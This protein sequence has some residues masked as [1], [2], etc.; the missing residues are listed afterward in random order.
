MTKTARK[1]LLQK[2]M[3]MLMTALVAVSLA[4]GVV[5]APAQPIASGSD[6]AASDKINGVGVKY[7]PVENGLVENE[8][9]LS[10]S[11]VGSSA[12]KGP[13]PAPGKNVDVIISLDGTP[14]MDYATER[15]MTVAQSLATADGQKNLSKLNSIRELALNGISKYIIEKR[16]DY[17]T[18]MNAFSATVKYGDIAAIERN[19]N[20]K[21]VILSQ[22]YLAPQ[23]ITENKVDVYESGIFNSAGVGYDG[24]GTV[25]A[26]VDTGTDYT[27]EVFDMEL[28]ANT[29]AINKDDVARVASVLTAT[30]LSAAEGEN[31]NED[32]LYISSKLPFAYDYA[33][34]D[35]NVYPNSSHGT[36][37]AGIIAGKSDTIT[38]V[39]PRAQIATFKVF[40]D[41]NTGAKT[42]W[43]LAGL[44]DAVTLGVDA[45]NMSLGSSC[46]FTRE[47]DEDNIN[48][49]YD[50]I[51]AAGICLVVAASNDASSAQGSTWGNTNLATN[52]DSGTVGSP[53][54]YTAA[55]SVASVSGVKTKYFMVDNSEVYF[56]ESRLMG[57]TDPND[58]V[59]GMLKGATEG[60]FEYI[61]IPG[62]GIDA[63]YTTDQGE[64]DVAGKIAV[65]KRGVSNFEAK[66][67]VAANHGAIGVIV[68][69]N[70]SGTIGMSVGT[71]EVIPSC[72]VT[73][74]YAERLVASGKGKI[75]LS[76][77]YLAGPFMSDF[78]SW[79]ALPNLVLAPDITAH[80]GDIYSS[81]AGG[82]QYD[83]LSGTSMACPNLAG[84]LILVREF[85]KE[86]NA[87][88]TAPQVRDE[89][90]SRM[91]STATIVRNEEGNPYSPRK[92]G[93]GIANI[94]D[95]INTKA[96]LT[97]D[98]SN[99]PKISLGDDPD[100]TGVYEFKFNLVN[101]SSNA[102]SYD[103]DQLVMT[104]SMSS[105]DITVA[106]KAYMFDDTVNTYSI[107]K[108]KGSSLINGNTVTVGGYGEV[109]VNAR[110]QLSA[111]D[112]QYIDGL[113]KNG[114]FVEGYVVL[115]SNNLD[116]IDLNIPFM[117]FY[118]NW[119]DAPMLD[120]SAYEV[121]E[122]AVDDSVKDEDKLKAD[123]YGTLPYSG[124][125]STYGADNMGYWGMGAY[126]FNTASGYKTPVTQEKFAALSNNSDGD[127]MLYMI[128]AGLL[129]CAKRV[130]MEIRNSATGELVWSGVDYN[131]RKSHGSGGTQTGGSVMI[132]LDIR[133]LDLPNNSKYTFSMTCYLDWKGDNS[134]VSDHEDQIDHVDEYT[135]GN[136][137]TF[138]FEFT[139]DDEK[140]EISSAALRKQKD[141]NGNYRYALE[142]NLYDNHY[143]Q[144][145]SIYT[146][147]GKE[148]VNGYE[149]LT[150][151]TSLV[152]GVIP[153]DGEFNT[154]TLCSH[155][156]SGYWDIIQKNGGKLYVMMYDYAKNSSAYEMVIT[157]DEQDVADPDNT[158]LIEPNSDLKIKKDR[159]AREDYTLKVNEQYDL[160]ALFTV[161]ANINAGTDRAPLYQEGYWTKD[162][163]WEVSDPTIADL[164]QLGVV[165]GLKEGETTVRVRTPNVKT[166]DKSDVDH[167]AEF[168]III[169]GEQAGG[170]RISGVDLSMTTLTL[171]RGETRTI[172]ATVKPYNY[173]GDVDIAWTV[174]SR[175]VDMVVSEDKMSVTI[176]ARNS[177]S[178]R[179]MASVNGSFINGSCDVYI[180]NEFVMYENIYL[181]SYNGKGGDFVNEKGEVEHNVVN[182]PDDL[183]I[184]Y[185]YPNAFYD[186]PDIRK[187]IIPEGVTEIMRFAFLGCENLEEVVLPSTLET[188]DYAVFA[189]CPKL[190]KINL[191]NVKIV[192]DS[193]FFNCRALEE[194]NLDKCTY[195]DKF[196]FFNCTSL[197]RMDLSRVGIIGGGAF[198]HCSALES[199]T[200]PSN[201]SMDFE[202]D[203]ERRIVGGAFAF[204]V[205]LKT[206]II[207]SKSVGEYAFLGC[208][209]LE[210]VIF[211]NDVE[212]INQYAFYNCE[213][214]K[215][216]TFHGSLYRIGDAAFYGC[217]ALQSITL[218][219]GL[220]VLGYQVFEGCDALTEINISSGALL[221]T[222]D[223]GSL[224]GLNIKAFNVENGN[225]Y[226]SSIDGVLYDRA[227]KRLIA[228]PGAKIGE[229]FAVPASVRTI[230]Q[231]AFAS[232]QNLYQI[233]LGKVEYIEKYAFFD[234]RFKT[235]L[236]GESMTLVVTFSSY[237][238]IKYIGEGAFMGA[239]LGNIPI[240]SNVTYIGGRAFYGA[241]MSSM[242]KSLTITMP[243]G[244]EYLG[245]RA[246]AGL[247]VK[248][249]DSDET[250]ILGLPITSVSFAGSHIKTVGEGVF[251]N[252]EKLTNIVGFGELE[253]LSDR[254]FVG[255]T[256]LNSVNI[257]KT[258]KKLGESVFEG[259]TALSNVNFA[260]DSA[261]TDISRNAFKDTGITS[262]TLPDSLTAIG[263]GAFENTR[264]AEINLKDVT[265]IGNR[266]FASTRLK[267]VASSKVKTVGNSAFADC[268]DLAS[269]DFANAKT[270]GNSAFKNCV[271]LTAVKL[272]SATDIGN[273]AFSGCKLMSAITL[274]NAKKIG[275]RAFADASA[276][277]AVGL[278]KLEQL[279][280]E[281]FSGTSVKTVAL[282]VSLY[283]VADNAFWGADK[284][285]SITVDKAN[286]KFIAE[287][288]VLYFLNGSGMYTLMCYPANKTDLKE[289]SV[290]RN[291]IRIGAYAFSANKT[292]EKLVFPAY[293]QIIGVSAMKGMDALTEITLNAVAAPTLESYA[294][295]VYPE[296]GGD[297][298]G[299]GS[300]DSDDDLGGKED[301]DE[302]INI[303]EG[304][305]TNFY[306]NFNF[307][308][309]DADKDHNLKIYIPA[310]SIGY[311][312]RIWNMYVGKNIEYTNRI[313]ATIG[314][315]ELVDQMIAE[316]EKPTHDA[317]NI[318]RLLS[319]YNMTSKT[320][321]QF[322][323]GNYDYKDTTASGEVL[324]VIDKEYYTEIFGGKNYVELLNQLNGRSAAASA[325]VG[326]NVITHVGSTSPV[327]IAVSCVL[328]CFLAVVLGAAVNTAIRRNRK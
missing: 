185:I 33:D 278:P 47:V 120:V 133:D 320:Q 235:V 2:L 148:F 20:V 69:N 145:Y 170:V 190:K 117:A 183:G 79:G 90:Y 253:Q 21:N 182:I 118:G 40:S 294:H 109:T 204:C 78:S 314:T 54:S 73:M 46:G 177:G 101:I 262:L 12:S 45:I 86:N 228:Y 87:N 261:V 7:T 225:K 68:Y 271:K 114:M 50:S 9:I 100:R 166:F 299:N 85:V 282:P 279:G 211:E 171:E 213:A 263:Y 198:Y 66:V 154:D 6:V 146:Y 26:V 243:N 93:A 80:G 192:G 138:S 27:H 162:L 186:N 181:R 242:I 193:A 254:M 272:T 116:G 222:I 131:A 219:D 248:L 124:F 49:V 8:Y 111:K 302:V 205:N 229:N 28:N 179:I 129:R 25:V 244:L 245:E 30:S 143:M 4:L 303:G 234:I 215:N 322:I 130:D 209:T 284:L 108:V 158:V 48:K 147:E 288:G 141:R 250:A 287:N 306:D 311:D 197:K 274:D 188:I 5:Y 110:I 237:D 264:I 312:N 232:A 63:D 92:Q 74:D 51:N 327:A 293:L 230:G 249:Q 221:E 32:D 125:Y 256:S 43:I 216:V 16:Y 240:E 212:V 258:V 140:P 226:L 161:S 160:G 255:C 214:L 88:Y 285:S 35:T 191:E 64:L 83:R 273:E 105:D 266:A 113:F 137:N 3:I 201:T 31:I 296:N 167:C 307:A 55:L 14:M 15:G 60:E 56:A 152:D 107:T 305:F 290:A 317:Q 328:V 24:T 71:K 126:A 277:G 123:V 315:L 29:L 298:I 257:P 252:S 168:K 98:G 210:N 132:E 38:G 323:I 236:Q 67:K 233:N 325:S 134:Y 75:K 11:A 295:M 165:T 326:E 297:D 239:A 218:P 276:L 195:I 139:I 19:K 241:S 61:V 275:S 135:L 203:E 157:D 163:I 99:K 102:V 72:F 62:I 291:T 84:A 300:I 58:F 89:S 196:A 172:T 65:V 159:K 153:V 39:A 199:V 173:T 106:E 23:A 176:T 316:L 200:I 41:H 44:N 324:G 53:G 318:R 175:N 91:M 127:Y 223:Y 280:G 17:T 247:K 103:L 308:F 319:L 77:S 208:E 34:S 246:F 115:K 259:C 178:A 301:E 136:K 10:E 52:P 119:A 59:G 227:Q 104:E 270:I 76:T 292:V 112:K 22:T 174:S 220:S 268:A 269:I 187:V 169:S 286:E 231:S 281:V 155:D 283:K 304:V 180:K 81:V 95:S 267:S 121:G 42:E 189:D 36:H 310:N 309:E 94:S 260:S 202:F 18:V 184:V 289:Y 97:V 96:F 207:K 82:D 217:D 149:R 37:V 57:K 206:V 122:S 1:S 313:H 70:V 238:N 13:T 164:T 265:S 224:G 142:M 144:G 194:V 128:N 150:G 251:E 321:Q 156:I 151:V